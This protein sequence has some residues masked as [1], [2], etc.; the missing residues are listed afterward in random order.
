MPAPT[1]LRPERTGPPTASP[2]PGQGSSTGA[3][4]L[5]RRT[6]PAA[7]LLILTGLAY[8][9]WLLAREVP[10]TNSD[11]ATMG[12]A[13]AHIAEGRHFPIFFYGQAYMGT[14]EAYL[15][16][17]LMWLLGETTVALRIPLL[18]LYVLFAA[19]AYRLTRTLYTPGLALFVT[20]LL[21]LGSDRIIKNQLIAGGGYP[22]INPA[23][24]WLILLSYLLATGRIRVRRARLAGLVGWGLIVGLLLWDSWLILP[25]V[26]AAAA[27]LAAGATAAPGTGPWWR[28]LLDR[29]LLRPLGTVAAG[30][31]VGAL[32]LVIHH[33]VRPLSENSISV[34]LRLNGAADPAPVADRLYGGVLFG[35]PMSAGACSPSRCAPWQMWWAVAVLVLLP[36]AVAL[37]VRQ[38]R[39]ATDRRERMLAVARLALL[40]AAVLTLVSYARS[41]AAGQTPVESARYLH[42]LL[43]SLPALLWPLWIAGTGHRPGS[44]SGSG[45][46]NVGL[47]VAG[48]TVLAGFLA[49]ALFATTA[50][51]AHSPAY[52]DQADRHRQLVAAL[53]DL[54]VRHMYSDYWTCNLTTFATREEIVCAVLADTQQPGEELRPGLDRYRA[55]P[56]RVAAADD[57]VYVQVADTDRDRST[58]AWLTA[59]GIRY[60][61]ATVAGYHIYRPVGRR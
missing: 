60:E 43:I 11:E 51:I 8:R 45:V 50:L 4:R 47:R 29:R 21:A 7:A 16:A 2:A 13:A 48:G 36:V 46:R 3:G 39:R 37:A 1:E 12:L 30:V 49:T 61:T 28:P 59:A 52:A 6:G 33:L 38:L 40:G 26:A 10:P 15:A 18:A 19:G 54:G 56:E 57:P 27:I 14:V 24:V 9:I 55:Y 22:E 17:P 35:I 41:A 25:Y 20:G 53:R 31:V 42:G 32:P 34:F 5:F 58:A 44:G 23:G